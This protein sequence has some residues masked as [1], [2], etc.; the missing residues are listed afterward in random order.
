MQ[1]HINRAE[2]SMLWSEELYEKVIGISVSIIQN[3]LLETVME[4]WGLWA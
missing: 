2:E 3:K 4:K 1:R